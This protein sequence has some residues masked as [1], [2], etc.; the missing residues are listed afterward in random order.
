MASET[1]ND[2]TEAASR[3]GE[4]SLEASSGSVRLQEQEQPATSSYL[5][6]LQH[7]LVYELTTRKTQIAEAQRRIDFW[8]RHEQ[9]HGGE[10][11]AAAGPSSR[12]ARDQF[13]RD[14]VDEPFLDDLI[15]QRRER[16][17]ELQQARCLREAI[18]ES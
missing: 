18:V 12:R 11:D 9:D 15:R 7:S 3:L 10:G 17:A 16:L 4:M 2:S 14:V 8:H 6:P 5:T 1:Y 13:G